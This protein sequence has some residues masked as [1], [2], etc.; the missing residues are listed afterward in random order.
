[1]GGIT[2]ISSIYGID[3][4]FLQ[5]FFF[6]FLLLFRHHADFQRFFPIEIQTENIGRLAAT[7]AAAS[8][9]SIDVG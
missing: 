2:R 4:F 9:I 7:A 6:F 1:M 8:L 3:V 5:G